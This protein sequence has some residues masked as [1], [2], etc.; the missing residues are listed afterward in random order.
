M[1]LPQLAEYWD[2]N[3]IRWTKEQKYLDKVKEF[4]AWLIQYMQDPSD[5]LFYDKY[6]LR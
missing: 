2:V 3:Y 1:P 4:Y 6:Y 5:H